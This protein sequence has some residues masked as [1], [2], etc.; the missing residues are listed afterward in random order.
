MPNVAPKATDQFCSNSLSK[1]LL[2]LYAVRRF[3]FRPTLKIKGSLHRKQGNELN[4]KHGILQT[5]SIVFVAMLL[6]QQERPPINY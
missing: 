4:D 1:A 2:Q 5:C 6:N 3:H